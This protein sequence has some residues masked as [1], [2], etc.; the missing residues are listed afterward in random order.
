[1]GQKVSPHGLRL[2][3]NKDWDAKWYSNKKDFA[4]YLSRDLKIR[5]YLAK[6][7]KNAG[8]AKVEIERNSKITLVMNDLEKENEEKIKELEVNY[9]NEINKLEKDLKNVIIK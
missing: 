8:I 3:I 6:N 5:D 7:L 2:G 4:T 9:N 1:M